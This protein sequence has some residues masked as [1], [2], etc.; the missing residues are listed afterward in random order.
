MGGSSSPVGFQFLCF[1]SFSLILSLLFIHG[2]MSTGI[3]PGG[4]GTA[5]NNGLVRAGRTHSFIANQRPRF[6][7]PR[8][9]LSYFRNPQWEILYFLKFGS[10]PHPSSASKSS[11]WLNGYRTA[12]W[13][14]MKRIQ[15][16]QMQLET[17]S[18]S[19]R[20]DGVRPIPV[21]TAAINPSPTMTSRKKEQ[22]RKKVLPGPLSPDAFLPTAI[23]DDLGSSNPSKA[24][25]WAENG[26]LMAAALEISSLSTPFGPTRKKSGGIQRSLS[27]LRPGETSSVVDPSRRVSN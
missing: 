15:L 19:R 21:P 25:G 16:L 20:G 26:L 12:Y 18:N 14:K 11:S 22:A 4:S 17:E 2:L 7:I 10:L 6:N 9:N 1:N 27:E 24:G 5:Y 13:E 23:S 8:G 3:I